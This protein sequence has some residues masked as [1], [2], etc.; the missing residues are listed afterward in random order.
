MIDGSGRYYYGSVRIWTATKARTKRMRKVDIAECVGGQT[1]ILKEAKFAAVRAVFGSGDGASTPSEYVTIAGVG[2]F[3]R[4]NGPVRAGR[5]PCTAE[6][7][8]IGQ[9][10]RV[11]FKAIKALKDA[12][13]MRWPGD[14]TMVVSKVVAKRTKLS[15]VGRTTAKYASISVAIGRR[16]G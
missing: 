15:L 14:A 9:L 8:I 7:I 11:L 3:T 13:N 10:C 2:K 5:N 6:R 12:L 4:T 1:G 16:R